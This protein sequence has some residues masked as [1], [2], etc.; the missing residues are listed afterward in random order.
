MLCAVHETTFQQRADCLMP[1]YKLIC[2]H[3]HNNNN[4]SNRASSKQLSRVVAHSKTTNSKSMRNAP[5]KCGMNGLYTQRTRSHKPWRPFTLICI[6]L[7]SEFTRFCWQI[8]WC[9]YD[10]CVYCPKTSEKRRAFDAMLWQFIANSSA[11]YKCWNI[12]F[13]RMGRGKCG[14]GNGGTSITPFWCNSQSIRLTVV[15]RGCAGCDGKQ[16]FARSR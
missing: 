10:Y 12:A 5:V 16:L 3:T 14:A 9:V 11:W 7:Q 4:H 15:E 2:A 8:S 13:V 1:I 6:H